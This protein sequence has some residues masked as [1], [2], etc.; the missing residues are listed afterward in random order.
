MARTGVGGALSQVDQL[1]PRL[2]GD[3]AQVSGVPQ[4]GGVSQVGRVTEISGVAQV[5][6]LPEASIV[7]LALNASEWT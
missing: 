7:P 6:Q 5:D 2:D 1:G 3:V 4:V